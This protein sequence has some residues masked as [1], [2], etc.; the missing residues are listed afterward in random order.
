MKFYLYFIVIILL[1]FI[2]C[3]PD[4]SKEVENFV[5]DAIP[6]STSIPVDQQITITL[7]S[8]SNMTGI[9]I[10]YDNFTTEFGYFNNLGYGTSKALYFYFDKVGSKTIYFKVKKEGNIISEVKSVTIDVVSNQAVKITGLQLISFTNINGTWD[11]E[12][13]VSNPNHLADVVFGLAKNTLN[14]PFDT[15]KSYKNWFTS[16]VKTNQGDLT[17][18]LTNENLYFDPTKILRIGFS[19]QDEP[20]LGQPLIN[21]SSG[22]RNIDLNNYLI[23][24]PSVISFSYPEIDLEF[25]MQLE[26]PN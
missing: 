11:P 17:W 8:E 5:I 13:N 9:I 7:A 4:N 19:D 2:S 14:N 10:S 25:K 6:S 21:D 12:Y 3:S 16:N 22:Y 20:P 26:W 24:K 15:N 18:N 1:L 23:T